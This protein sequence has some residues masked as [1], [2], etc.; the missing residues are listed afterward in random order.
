MESL[1]E[2]PMRFRES[3]LIALSLLAEVCTQVSFCSGWIV[4][5]VEKPL[6][7]HVLRGQIVRHLLDSL[8]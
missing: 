1:A 2:L 7:C 3:R 8:C 5:H 4:M 6:A